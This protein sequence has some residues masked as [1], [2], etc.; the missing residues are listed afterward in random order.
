MNQLSVLK[1]SGLILSLLLIIGCK[2][3]NQDQSYLSQ[4]AELPVGIIQAGNTDMY[5]EF[6]AAI[7]GVSNI[8]IRPQVSGYLNK[9]LVDEGDYVRA[10]Q[11]LFRIDDRPFLE[12]LKNAQASLAA[13]KANLAN[14]LLDL[15]RKKELLK[16]KMVSDLQVREAESVYA[17]SQAN[18]QQA[19]AAV[20]SARINVNFCNI[21]APVS[22]YIS[23]FNYRLGS[24]V[25]PTNADALTL[26]SD[27]REVYAYFSMG[28]NDFLNFQE[29]Y[30]GKSIKEK[31]S[32]TPAVS[33]LVSN[34]TIYD[35]TGKIDAVE[36]QFNKS[37]GSITLRAKFDNPNTILRTGNTGKIRIPQQWNNVVLVPIA[38]TISIQDKKYVFSLDKESKAVQIP[39]DIS[40]KSGD[41]YMVSKGLSAGD[42]YIITGFDRLQPGMPVKAKNTNN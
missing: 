25:A 8:E 37:T 26:L 41:N 12:Q 31:L 39:I 33:L 24:L 7:E 38:S 18:V 35:N 22:G 20:E 17:A 29:Q 10:G 34:G 27:I 1:S 9:I 3:K 21:T 5:S 23:R 4:V 36:G 2:Q 11:L 6:T 15:D 28:E 14:T 40:G 19:Q 30:A 13:S 42:Q 32:H 16:S